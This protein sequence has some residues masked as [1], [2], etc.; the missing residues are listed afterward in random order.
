M[1]QP[2]SAF[3]LR[4][5]CGLA[6]GNQR[7]YAGEGH[8]AGKHHSGFPGTKAAELGH[9]ALRLFFIPAREK[10]RILHYCHRGREQAPILALTRLCDAFSGSPRL[11]E[12]VFGSR[13]AFAI[14]EG[15]G[16]STPNP[17]G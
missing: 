15:G 17:T 6:T 2:P 8:R 14:S 16:K 3:L 11:D 10:N 1:R 12:M 13:T 5:I 9:P 7:P 4:W